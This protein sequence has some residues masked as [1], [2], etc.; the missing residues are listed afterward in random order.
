MGMM[1][2]NDVAAVRQVRAGDKDAFRVLVERHSR[3]IFRLAYRMT[4]REQDA[5]DLV[6]ETFLRAFQQLDRFEARSSF[7]TWLYRIAVNC[8]LDLL[9]KRQQREEPLDSMEAER[10]VTRMANGPLPDRL[11]FSTEIQGRVEAALDRL[12]PTERAAFVLRHF[13]EMPIKEVGRTLG[14]GTSSAK[15][16]LFRG[17]QKVRRILEPMVKAAR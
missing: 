4:G 15:N 7:G 8:S 1:G 5:E 16:T 12:T 17:V 13:E 11:V 10:E 2:E 6:Q 14:L 9:R 3:S